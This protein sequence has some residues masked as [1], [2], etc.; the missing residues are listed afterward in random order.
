MKDGKKK[1]KEKRLKIKT[2]ERPTGVKN[3]FTISIDNNSATW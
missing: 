1:E 2:K 3:E